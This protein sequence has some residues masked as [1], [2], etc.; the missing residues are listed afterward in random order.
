MR[1]IDADGLRRRIVA[2]CTGC[3]TTYLTVEN[4]VMMIN[5]ADTV[6]AVPA[7]RCRDCVYAQSAKINKKGFLICPASRME[8]TDD[9]FCSYGEKRSEPPVQ[10]R[11]ELE[12][13][14]T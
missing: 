13:G 3:S 8:I 1:V 6:D 11:P 2:F 12:G 14:I 4:I 9:D 7:V 10:H 5:Q